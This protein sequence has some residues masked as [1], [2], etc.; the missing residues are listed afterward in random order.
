MF[1]PICKIWFIS[2]VSIIVYGSSISKNETDFN[3]LYAKDS[4]PDW[5]EY[6]GDRLFVIKFNYTR[7]FTSGR[8]FLLDGNSFNYRIFESAPARSPYLVFNVYPHCC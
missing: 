6:F 2:V 4:I 1:S 7:N 3:D 8:T 5:P